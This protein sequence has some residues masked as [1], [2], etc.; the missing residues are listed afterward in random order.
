MA[1]ENLSAK[2]ASVFKKLEGRGT[3]GEKDVK[4]ALREVRLALLE[5]DVNFKVVKD[6]VGKIT[7][8]AVGEEVLR[9][10]TPGQQVL[11]IVNAELT[12]LLGGSHS[13]LTFSPKPPTVFVLAGLQGAGKTT[14]C[15]KLA[16]QMKKQNKK[17]LLVACDIYRPAAIK[18]L[19]VLGESYGVPVYSEES[20]KDPAVIAA[21]SLAHAAKAGNDVIIIDTAGRLHIDDELMDELVRIKKNV[22]PQ[23]ILLTVDAMTGQDAVNVARAF[24]EKLGIDGIIITKLDGDARGG[25]ALSVRAATGRPIKFAGMGEKPDPDTLEPFHPDRMASRILGMGDVMSLIEKAQNLFD[26]EEAAKLE[27]KIRQQELSLED[28]LA[29]LKQIRKMGPLTDLIGMIPGMGRLSLDEGASE[30]SLNRVEAIICSM[31]PYERRNPSVLNG[32]RKRR[33]AAGSGRSVQEVNSLLKQFEE[34]KRMMKGF[35]GAAG[36]KGRIGAPFFG[37]R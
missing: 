1:F 27:K 26:E 34:M 32:S 22:R 30:K 2:L 29:Q 6:F 4:E 14:A 21:N 16:G 18:Q 10:L 15:A 9:S 33:V 35:T 8:K 17:P 19:K 3:L 24:D 31:T 20:N 11:K 7:E 5:A 23:E 37:G 36:K 25:A 28:F 12:E 13:K